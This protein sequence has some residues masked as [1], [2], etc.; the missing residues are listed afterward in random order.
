MHPIKHL[1]EI[2]DRAINEKD[3]DTLLETYADDEVLVIKPGMN[4]VGK[5]QIKKAFETISTHFENTLHVQQ[6]AMEILETGDTALV[7][8]NTLK[9]ARNLPVT[10]RKAAYVFKKSSDAQWV[11]C[12]DNSY[13]H[14]L[15]EQIT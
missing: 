15:L 13:G 14:D 3:F 5:G 1:I 4:A 10:S 12:I 6:A 7:L 2:A 11:C 9:S 8:A